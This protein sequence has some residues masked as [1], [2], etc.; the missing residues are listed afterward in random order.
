[1]IY[2][3]G[4]TL[5]ITSLTDFSKGY[6]APKFRNVTST[7]A[8]GS[9]EEFVDTDFPLFRLADAYLIYAEAVVRGGGGSRAT[10][11]GYVNAIRQRAYGDNSG[12]IT[13]AELTADFILAERG[14]ELFWEAHRRTDLIRFDR[15]TT[16]G[17][18]EWKGGV[19]PGQV[20]DT[21]LNLYPLPATQLAANPN[22]DQNPGY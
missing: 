9:D 8:D 18:W 10:A 20:T 16:N 5:S 6:A 14:R 11:L 22:L 1:V 2:T 7:G 21:H 4:Q 12:D 13:D 15:F 17:I 3:D 19:Q